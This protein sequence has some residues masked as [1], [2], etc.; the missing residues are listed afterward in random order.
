MNYNLN[1]GYGMLQASSLK[2]PTN[3]KIFVVAAASSGNN[4]DRLSNIYQPDPDG[5]SR[6]H[7]TPTL[8]LAQCVAGRADVVYIDPSY[9]TP[10]SEA[11]LESAATKAVSVAPLLAS[12]VDGKYVTQSNIAAL[13]ASADGSLFTVTG[14]VKVLQIIGEV[15]TVIQTQANNTLLKHNPTVGADVDLCVALDISADADG[16]LYSI[17]GTLGDAL[18][19]TASAAVPEQAAGIVL[20]AGIIELECAATN[21]GAVK[22][23]V[24]WESVDPGSMILKA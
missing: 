19:N 21:T 3:G 23:T 13:P 2:N 1:S 9:S 15:T 18:I 20:T 7:V 24:V 8:A 16:S 22:W 11:E 17:T 10:L 6:L 4:Y 12:R 14:K 5:V